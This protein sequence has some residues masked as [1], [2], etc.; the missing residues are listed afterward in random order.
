MKPTKP[1]NPTGLRGTRR[2]NGVVQFE[3]CELVAEVQC[4]RWLVQQ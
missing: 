3:D 1:T 2:A 4:G